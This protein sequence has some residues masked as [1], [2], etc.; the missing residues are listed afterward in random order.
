MFKKM[1]VSKDIGIDLGTATVIVYVQDKGIVLNE[2]SV[3][4][5]DMNADRIIK[6]GKDARVM[7]GREPDGVKAIRPLRDGVI[8][9]YDITLKMLQYFL[10]CNLLFFLNK[11]SFIKLLFI[12]Y[13]YFFS[14]NPDCIY[15]IQYFVLTVKQ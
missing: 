12:R 7:L 10:F 15:F 14:V 6:V 4:A 13:R 8:S 3:V 11:Q 1:K 5:I 2:P 9:H